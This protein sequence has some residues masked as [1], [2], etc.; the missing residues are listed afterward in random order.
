MSN[1]KTYKMELMKRTSSKTASKS[2]KRQIKYKFDRKDN[3]I[4]KIKW[5][6]P[7]DKKGNTFDV[8][9]NP[10]KFNTIEIQDEH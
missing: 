6:S 5:K 9:V 2:N 7:N 8:N 4:L 1:N 3:S 10:K